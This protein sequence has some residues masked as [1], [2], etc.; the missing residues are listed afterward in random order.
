MASVGR[1]N[2]HTFNYHFGAHIPNAAHRWPEPENDGAAPVLRGPVVPEDAFVILWSGGFNLWTD[3]AMLVQAMDELM[4][5]NSRVHFVSTGGKLEGVDTQTYRR[6]EE[7]VE[8]SPHRE[9]Y[10]RLGWVDS[11]RI[12]RIYREANVGLNVDG[13]NYETFFGARNRIN[14]MAAEGLA[15]CTTLGTEI[16][17]WLADGEAIAVARMG[18]PQSLVEAI[19]PWIEQPEQLAI[20]RR[21]AREIMERDFSYS[22]TTRALRAWLESPTLSPDNEAKIRNSGGEIHDLNSGAVNDLAGQALL[23]EK[24]DARAFIQ[25]ARELE[26]LKKKPWFRAFLKLRKM[27]GSKGI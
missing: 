24:I 12:P 4:R 9:R 18:D 15:V 27:L 17:E 19:E 20:Y 10:H 3:I 13:P 23:L 11:S 2:R 14:A 8:A 26:Q 7:A 25:T 16:S 22:A 21:R 5:Q 6:F 1:L